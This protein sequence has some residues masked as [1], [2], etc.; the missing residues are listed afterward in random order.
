MRSNQ[1][2][3]NNMKKVTDQINKKM[4]KKQKCQ[5][6]VEIKYREKKQHNALKYN[7]TNK[8]NFEHKLNKL[9]L[10]NFFKLFSACA[11]LS[12]LQRTLF[13]LSFAQLVQ[14]YIFITYIYTSEM[15]NQS[16]AQFQ[17]CLV[18]IFID[19]YNSIV[20]KQSIK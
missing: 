3:K 15:T 12:K 19:F 1:H 18:F 13:I 10:K 14:K 2:L 17:L 20:T 9:K 8:E 6:K 5:I 7:T 16:I 4:Y 11:A